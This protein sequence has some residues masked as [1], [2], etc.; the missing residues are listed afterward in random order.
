MS[1]RWWIR[2]IKILND[3]C[4]NERFVIYQGM[5]IKK[6]NKRLRIKIAL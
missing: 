1:N 4:D 2:K 6:R 3:I 5:M